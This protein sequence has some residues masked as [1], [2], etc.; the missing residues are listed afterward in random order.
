VVAGLITLVFVIAATFAAPRLGIR[1]RSVLAA[2]LIVLAF[3]ISVPRTVARDI[4][5]VDSREHL[6]VQK[7][8]AAAPYF[9]YSSRFPKNNR[10]LR[11]VLA[12]LE[13]VPP[14]AVIG[15]RSRLLS[16]WA[17]RAAFGLAPR[18]LVAGLDAPW[19]ILV[20]EEPAEAVPGYRRAW[21][22]R[23]LWLVER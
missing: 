21:R 8:E 3:A 4:R 9:R 12:A 15:M 11:L 18:R 19:V 1:H 13:R 17:R 22:F 20:G 23:G 7:S 16:S 10:P 5:L 14:D 2:G 6:S